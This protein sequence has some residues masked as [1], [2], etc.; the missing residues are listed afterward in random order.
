[1]LRS[2]FILLLVVFSLSAQDVIYDV[3]AI[4]VPA[5]TSQSFYELEVF[6]EGHPE[7][8]LKNPGNFGIVGGHP[9]LVVQAGSLIKFEGRVRVEGQAG[10]FKVRPRYGEWLKNNT[11]TVTPEM[12]FFQLQLCGL[13]KTGKIRASFLLEVV[14]RP[15]VKPVVKV[16]TN[17]KYKKYLLY[18]KEQLT[19]VIREKRQ[20]ESQLQNE[21][22]QMSNFNPGWI[23]VGL[24]SNF[25]GKNSSSLFYQ[26]NLSGVSMYLTAESREEGDDGSGYY[27]LGNFFLQPVNSMGINITVAQVQSNFG[28]FYERSYFSVAVMKGFQLSDLNAV[29]IGADMNKYFRSN[30]DRGNLPAPA[31]Y[32]LTFGLSQAKGAGEVMTIMATVNGDVWRG[33]EGGYGSIYLSNLLPLQLYNAKSTVETSPLWHLL[34]T[35]DNFFILAGQISRGEGNYLSES[36]FSASGN[37]R[38][39]SR[40]VSGFLLWNTKVIS[41]YISGKYRQKRYA[42]QKVGNGPLEIEGGIFF[43]VD[44]IKIGLSG[45]S[46]LQGGNQVGLNVIWKL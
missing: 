12:E 11:L 31:S 19:Q 15:E 41:G 3:R 20:R 25:A 21:L 32:G 34:A 14:V 38:E 1:M 26:G 46:D 24:G 27:V 8:G 22:L 17:E 42:L 30:T 10:V 9:I 40:Q 2:I 28:S 13:D 7:S 5:D 43:P 39:F 16:M 4:V 37:Y 35:E 33:V 36:L 23:G 6:A 44:R 18:K 29:F 45:Q